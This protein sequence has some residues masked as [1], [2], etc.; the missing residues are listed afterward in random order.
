MTK[1]AT[2][3]DR[4]FPD[5]G[6]VTPARVA[7]AATAYAARAGARG[8]HLGAPSELRRDRPLEAGP[9]DAAPAPRA[10]PDPVPRAE[11][12]AARRRPCPSL[13]GA[14]ARRPRSGPCQGGA[15]SD[16]HRARTK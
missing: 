10:T 4:A 15:R 1:V 7:R 16:P 11:S 6:R 8:R 2:D 3:G 5:R 14:V 13:P 9:R 12:A